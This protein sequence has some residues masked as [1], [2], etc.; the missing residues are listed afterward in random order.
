MAPLAGDGVVL[1]WKR[2]RQL[3]EPNSAAGP[4]DCGATPLFL[5][6]PGRQSLTGIG[7]HCF[8]CAQTDEQQPRLA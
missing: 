8:S 6:V 2:R 7:F 4:D 3:S 5:T 1:A